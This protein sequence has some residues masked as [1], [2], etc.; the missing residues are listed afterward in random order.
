MFHGAEA[1]FVPEPA[2]GRTYSVLRRAQK[3]RP[4]S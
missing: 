2:G 4:G 1:F 3:P